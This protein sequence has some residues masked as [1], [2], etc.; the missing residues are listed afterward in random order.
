VDIAGSGEVRLHSQPQ[1]IRSQVHGSGRII[2]MPGEHSG[3]AAAE[4]TI[5]MEQPMEQL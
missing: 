2:G 5:A 1:H 4:P 3:G